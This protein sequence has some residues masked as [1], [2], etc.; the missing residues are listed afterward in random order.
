[1]A[2]A[3]QGVGDLEKGIKKGE[4]LE[5]TEGINVLPPTFYDFLLAL[6]TIS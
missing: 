6:L 1:M 5:E 2:V 4:G 3:Q